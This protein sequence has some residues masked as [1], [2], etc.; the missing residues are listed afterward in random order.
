MSA[1]VHKMTMR[2]QLQRDGATGTNPWGDKNIPAFA[3]IPGGGVLTSCFAWVSKVPGD[4]SDEDR[5][6]F[7]EFKRMTV[8]LGTDVKV[9][10]RV[11]KIEDR[12][13][14]TIFAGPLFIESVERRADHL[15][16]T[17]R[18]HE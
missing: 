14:Q 7:V 1:A 17:L 3:D 18:E 9:R 10:D 16:L 4:V 5:D 2:A 13:A 11:L 15:E 8:A 6:L 12:R